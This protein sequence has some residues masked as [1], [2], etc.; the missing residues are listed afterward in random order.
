LRARAATD[1]RASGEASCHPEDTGEPYREKKYL[2]HQ[3]LSDGQPEFT[4]TLG[5][6]GLG[7][8]ASR[9]SKLKDVLRGLEETLLKKPR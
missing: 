5:G 9:E 7:G 4:K 6:D 1:K 8:C 3:Y 2:L